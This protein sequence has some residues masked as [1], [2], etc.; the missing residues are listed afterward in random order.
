MSD[1]VAEPMESVEHEEEEV[2]KCL[3]GF[4]IFDGGFR[5]IELTILIWAA[6]LHPE[7][8]FEL[9]CK[10][11]SRM[12]RLPDF[13]EGVL[14][15]ICTERPERFPGYMIVPDWLQEKGWRYLYSSKEV[16]D[17]GNEDK[18][19]MLGTIAYDDF[20]TMYEGF[21]TL[22][23]MR[24]MVNDG[25]GDYDLLAVPNGQGV[26]YHRNHEAVMLPNDIEI[27]ADDLEEL[28]HVPHLV[29]V[30]QMEDEI[31]EEDLVRRY[32]E[33]IRGEPEREFP[34]REAR[35]RELR[36]QFDE[37]IERYRQMGISIKNP[38]Y[39][40]LHLRVQL[41]KAQE[42]ER[43]LRHQHN[44]MYHIGGRD[45]AAFERRLVADLNKFF[46]PPPVP[47][48]VIT[49]RWQ[50]GWLVRGSVFRFCEEA[51]Q[52]LRM[53]KYVG[54]GCWEGEIWFPRPGVHFIGTFRMASPIS[55]EYGFLDHVCNFGMERCARLMIGQ[56]ISD[57]EGGKIID[58]F[59]K[60]HQAEDIRRLEEARAKQES[61]DAEQE[62]VNSIEDAE[63]RKQ[64][65]EEHNRR[66]AATVE[67]RRQAKREAE[68]DY[69]MRAR[70]QDALNDVHSQ[71]MEI[72]DLNER[73]VAMQLHVNQML[74]M[75]VPE[76]MLPQMNGE[77]QGRLARVNRMRALV[78]VAPVRSDVPYNPYR[79]VRA[80][81]EE[82]DD[83]GPPPPLEDIGD[84][85]PMDLD[86]DEEE[87]EERDEDEHVWPPP[88]Q[89]AKKPP[90]AQKV[91][92][93]RRKKGGK[94]KKKN[95][96]KGHK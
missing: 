32:R 43:F 30:V 1:E 70:V 77:D 86:D 44:N 52:I 80:E 8:K 34:E 75:G 42:R 59:P 73:A 17:P 3:V 45:D 10:L 69:Q 74:Q 92:G 71:I 61:L 27:D 58:E 63:V 19:L 2:E 55:Y 93:I 46:N 85:V 83:F 87:E 96:K 39:E 38:D 23:N 95:K 90:P 15:V 25:D 18:A 22:G 24:A 89:S 33:L 35:D 21:W 7:T 67:A 4:P 54:M 41:L 76:E 49:G 31:D 68:I 5:E 81:E 88:S 57:N 20:K 51:S 37:L 50:Q 16:V 13:R 53:D 84:R 94:G 29:E 47:S 6:I 28:I 65:R 79:Q 40:D 91:G 36:L 64:E 9:V 82:E 48:L 78:G 14:G 56:V 12:M 72:E 62:R 60:P 11:W 26:M 66:L